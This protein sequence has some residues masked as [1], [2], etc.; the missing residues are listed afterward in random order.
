MYGS[1]FQFTKTP[2]VKGFAD[3]MTGGLEA[4]FDE[5]ER[6]MIYEENAEKLLSE[7]GR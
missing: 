5:K 7:R 3:R 4:L 1:E 2:V 6:E